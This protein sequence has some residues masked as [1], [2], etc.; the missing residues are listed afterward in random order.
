MKELTKEQNKI[1]EEYL[2]Y[3]VV[4]KISFTGRKSA[5]RKYFNYL[6]SLKIDFLNIKISEAQDYQQYLTLLTTD[7]GKAYYTAPTILTIIGRIK[8]FYD[9]LKTQKLTWLNPFDEITRIRGEKNL[10]RD[11]L[12]EE[13][14]F[15]VLNYLKDFNKGRTLTE[16]RTLYKA[17]VIAELMYSTGARINEIAKLKIEDVDFNRSV[18]K[19]R[20]SKTGKER[21][22]I[23]NSFVEKVLKIFIENRQ[24][25]LTKKNDVNL[26]FGSKNNLYKWINKTMTEALKKNGFKIK[27]KSHNFRHSVA[28]HLLKNGCDI[29]YIQDLLGHKSISTT[30]IY[31]K[32]VKE[33][34]KRIIDN[35]HPRSIKR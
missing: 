6:N 24:Y 20:D 31:T 21:F 32:V 8:S 7:S 2:K 12:N 11:I 22:G 29:R 27:F 14:M 4:R 26:L 15:K 19:L 28:S 18:V 23:L 30:Q 34:L 17:H 9:Y 35:Y 13:D 1:L 16:K 25:V 33:D 10:P 3:L 5:I